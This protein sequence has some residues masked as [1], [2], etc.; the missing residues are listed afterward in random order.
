MVSEE[1]NTTGAKEAVK[2]GG[3]FPQ[4]AVWTIVAVAVVVIA[5]IAVGVTL[6]LSGRGEANKAPVITS[7]TAVPPVVS[8][9]GYSTITCVASDPEGSIVSYT[10]TA[11]GG[12][13]SGIGNIVS[14][15]APNVAGTFS[16]GVTVN[17]GEGG[18]TNNSISV[19]VSAVTPTPT[20]IPTSTPTSTSTPVPSTAPAYGAIDIN[21]SPSGA[22]IYIDGIENS[23]VTPYTIIHVA[24]GTHHVRLVY[25]DYKWREG[26]VTVYGGETTDI[27]WVLELATV[28]NVVIQ[29]DA[30]AGKD[31]F[32][33]EFAPDT[34]YGTEPALFVAGDGGYSTRAYI[35]F[36]LSSVPATAVILSADLELFYYT[37]STFSVDGPVGV[38]RVTGNWVE[39]TVTWNASPA[40][41]NTSIDTI[42]VP[43]AHTNTFLPW[44][45]SSLVQGW[46]DGSIAN[47]GVILRDTDESSSDGVKYFRSSDW[48]TADQRPKLVISYYDPA[49]P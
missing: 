1:G 2:K 41:T 48:S 29:P 46:V 37:E 39:S 49:A 28:Q 11:T 3:K 44:D 22:A 19:A 34:N 35:Q 20:P 27:N 5:G 47:R 4:W 43:G 38:Y 10:W 13:I 7:F 18:A 8:P 16:V 15:I 14:W 36:T 26:N 30:A 24:A 6:A 23:N 45:V 40:A 32:V 25:P 21:S 12:A 31:A 33:D 17:D 9:G 42:T